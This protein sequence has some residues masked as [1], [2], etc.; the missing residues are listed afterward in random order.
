MREYLGAGHSIPEAVALLSPQ[1][2]DPEKRR[3]LLQS[4]AEAAPGTLA[5]VAAG[6][7]LSPSRLP[8]IVGE[9]QARLSLRM[10]EQL[11]QEGSPISGAALAYLDQVAV[12]GKDKPRPFHREA[13]ELAATIRRQ[14]PSRYQAVLAKVAQSRKLG[15][16]ID[17]LLAD[18]AL[19]ARRADEAGK[20]GGDWQAIGWRLGLLAMLGGEGVPAQ[21]R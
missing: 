3:R 19:A 18:L 9:E 4:I 15:R 10:I 16:A 6:Y 13:A 11:V 2:H 20:P 17:E 12:Q 8:Q 14:Q 21:V 1:G 7:G 5:T